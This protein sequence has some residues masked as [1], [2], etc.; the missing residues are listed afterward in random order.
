MYRV[1][2]R[3]REMREAH[4]VLLRGGFHGATDSGERLSEAE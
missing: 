3:L 1:I 2:K 4:Y